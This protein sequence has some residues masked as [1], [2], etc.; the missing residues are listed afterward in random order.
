MTEHTL[1]TIRA[2][3]DATWNEAREIVANF[4]GTPDRGAAWMLAL[5]DEAAL[6]A[7]VADAMRRAFD[8]LNAKEAAEFKARYANTSF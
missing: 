8:A 6:P 3:A 5:S 4:F 7:R 2:Y 1:E